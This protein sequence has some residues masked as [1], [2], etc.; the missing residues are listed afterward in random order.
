MER[1][2]DAPLT[3]I[4]L[5]C[6]RDPVHDVADWPS[7]DHHGPCASAVASNWRIRGLTIVDRWTYVIETRLMGDSMQH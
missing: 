6:G 3:L 7:D 1:T 4:R 2:H 5:R